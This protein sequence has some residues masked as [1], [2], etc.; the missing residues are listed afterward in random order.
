MLMAQLRSLSLHKG[1]LRS[2]TSMSSRDSAN[3]AKSCALSRGTTDR[4]VDE[5]STALVSASRLVRLAKILPVIRSGWQSE[6]TPLYVAWFVSNQ[7]GM[8]QHEKQSTPPVFDVVHHLCS[9]EHVWMV[10]FHR[11]LM[12]SQQA[13]TSLLVPRGSTATTFQD[14]DP[15]IRDID[16]SRH[17]IEMISIRLTV[18]SRSGHEPTRCA[19][20]ARLF[21]AP[22]VHTSWTR[23]TCD[24]WKWPCTTWAF[25]ETKVVAKWLR[26][27]GLELPTWNQHDRRKLHRNESS[28]PTRRS[29]RS[30]RRSTRNCLKKVV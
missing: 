20:V 2:I 26:I 13:R 23:I 18:A 4:S 10:V 12:L 25:V 14:L 7:R 21:A 19:A 9:Y 24:A 27:D 3:S 29:E 30:L 5:R 22:H 16:V 1:G 6:T 28:R 11:C 15:M 8:V 17:F